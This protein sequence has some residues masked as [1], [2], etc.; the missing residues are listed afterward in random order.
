MNV[1]ASHPVGPTKA[2]RRVARERVAAY[3]QA[4]LSELIDRVRE[5]SARFDAGEFDAFEV[6]EAIHQY[7]RAAREL[8]KFCSGTGADSVR[9]A[10]TLD[11]WE[12]QGELPDWWERGAY[13]RRR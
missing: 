5:S 3:H 7:H 6:D 10:S 12:A 11:Y 13:R 8:W 1:R 9:A 2:E 4:R